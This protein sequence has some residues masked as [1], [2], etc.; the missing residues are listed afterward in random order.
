MIAGGIYLRFSFTPVVS[1]DLAWT[2]GKNYI[3]LPFSSGSVRVHTDFLH[4]KRIIRIHVG[5]S[6]SS[7]SQEVI[8]HF[9][10]SYVC[11]YV[12]WCRKD[13]TKKWLIMSI[14]GLQL[15]HIMKKKEV[16]CATLFWAVLLWDHYV[17]HCHGRNELLKYTKQYTSNADRCFWLIDQG[18]SLH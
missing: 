13:V 18:K 12:L 8:Q 2:K 4:H 16:S 5:K 3:L 17:T 15:D 6:N 11:I 7:D 14:I 10:A 9:N 1:V